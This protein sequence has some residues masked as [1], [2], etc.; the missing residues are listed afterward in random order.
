[1]F[2]RDFMSWYEHVVPIRTVHRLQL[3]RFHPA[4]TRPKDE[5]ATARG[6]QTKREKASGRP[7]PSSAAIVR[8]HLVQ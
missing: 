8:P 2:L 4:E 6:M 5:A 3:L 1:M 7:L